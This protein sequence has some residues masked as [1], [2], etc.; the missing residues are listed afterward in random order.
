MNFG[1]YEYQ[2]TEFA[3]YPEKVG[4]FYTALG[5]AGEAGEYA[6]KIKKVIRDHDS[7]PSVLR[8]DL[9]AE[10]GDVLWYLQECA[11]QL[12][13]SLE[14]VAV[15]NINKLSSRLVRNVLHGS[16]DNR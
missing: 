3:R 5:L 7:D 4:L 13:V 12:N 8:D 14:E 6:D 15:R 2:A 16:G 10:L 1:E 9:I 11:R